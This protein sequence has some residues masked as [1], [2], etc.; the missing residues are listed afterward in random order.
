MPTF[1]AC[2]SV[3]RIVSVVSGSGPVSGEVL[4]EDGFFVLTEDGFFIL[5]G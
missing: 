5:L 2:I 4:T 1:D 3:D